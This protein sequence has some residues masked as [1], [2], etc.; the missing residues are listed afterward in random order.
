MDRWHRLGLA[1]R[2]AYRTEEPALI[3]QYLGLGSALVRRGELAPPTAW[4]RMLTLLLQ[5]AGDEALP[6]F[7]RS[8]CLEH[9]AL[10]LARI[11]SAAGAAHCCPASSPQTQVDQ[12]WARLGITPETRR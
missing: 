6:W 5:T 3:R 1:I 10:P 12:A 7:W 4:P 2:L 11:R 8:V 9:T